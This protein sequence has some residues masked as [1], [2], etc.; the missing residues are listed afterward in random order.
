MRNYQTLT[1]IGG[2]INILIILAVG[3]IIGT[4]SSFHESFGNFTTQ[5]G[6]QQYINKFYQNRASMNIGL[7][8]VTVAIPVSVVASIIGM[9]LVFVIKD[10]FKA[11]GIILI[12]LGVVIVIATSGFGIVGFAMFI[13]AGIVALRYK[14]KPMELT[15]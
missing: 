15:K 1:I 3:L 8:Y 11:L 2:I 9:V 7:Q 14:P 10:K 5:Y 4:L 12:V 6:T 13:V